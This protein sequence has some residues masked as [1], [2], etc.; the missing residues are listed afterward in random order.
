M[1]RSSAFLLA[2]GAAICVAQQQIPGNLPS[3]Y[4]KVVASPT[5]LIEKPV[6][7][8]DGRWIAFSS[9]EVGRSN[10]W[11]V[12]V[13]GGAP[14]LVTTGDHDDDA[15][16][17]SPDGKRIFFESDRAGSI[18]AIGFDPQT[19]HAAGAPVRVGLERALDYTVSP[20]G[21]RIAYFT[22]PAAGQKV[23]LRVMP[24][25]GGT[26]T[27]LGEFSQ[28]A[29]P[30]FPQISAD[31]KYVY[32]V[33]SDGARRRAVTRVPIAGG[34]RTV[35][36]TA[37]PGG[38]VLSSTLHVV[39]PKRMMMLDEPRHRA[40]VRNYAGDTVAVFP[41]PAERSSKTGGALSANGKTAIIA[42]KREIAAIR[43]VPVDGGPTRIVGDGKTYEWPVGFSPDSRQVLY[44]PGDTVDLISATIDGK[45]RTVRSTTPRNM[46]VRINAGGQ[47]AYSADRR[48]MMYVPPVPEP[49]TGPHVY[50]EDLQTHTA[51]E[52]TDHRAPGVLFLTGAGDW[53]GTNHGEFLYG[54]RNGDRLELRSV[55]PTGQPHVIAT[56]PAGVKRIHYAVE[57]DVIA[58]AVEKGDSSTLSVQRGANLQ[59]R[60]IASVPG[61]IDEVVLSHNAKWMAV[62]I[63]GQKNGRPHSELQFIPTDP[64]SGRA[65]VISLT[66]G[67]YS[68]TWSPDD[69]A[70][71]YLKADHDWTTTAIWRYPLSAEEAPRN[72]T[73]NEKVLI[74]GFELS[75][76]G[77]Y[78]A[79]PAEES[80]GS[81]LWTVNLET[82][83]KRAR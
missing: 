40:V 35:V 37:Y 50:I 77:K 54:E 1:I 15:P 44:A 5:L 45:A 65:R 32:L 22:S 4:Q 12:A 16:V 69:E 25:T 64:S 53:F 70:I 56:A 74:W 63:E 29:N 43:V 24:A 30:R 13:R 10:I 9:S 26:A 73:P 52:I 58:F 78:I 79:F 34:A 6:M 11:V 76:D 3:Y 57:G 27:T 71:F 8:P 19:G 83:Q 21:S 81:V 14:V 60:T 67:G 47:G 41:L 51:R 61:R 80:G 68:A 49:G 48:Y 18:M 66:D 31:G 82:V 62:T 20:D 23:H 72:V 55:S 75:P 39:E 7:S 42:S 28:Q 36:S 59:P 38:G 33:E 46:T 17:W 2:A